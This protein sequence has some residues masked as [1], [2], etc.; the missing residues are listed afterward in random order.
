MLGR[1]EEDGRKVEGRLGEDG[2]KVEGS[3]KVLAG[4]RDDESLLNL[5]PLELLGRFG[6]LVFLP[7]VDLFLLFKAFISSPVAALIRVSTAVSMNMD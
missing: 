1:W 4:R 7:L 2:W 3:S 5:S 6:L